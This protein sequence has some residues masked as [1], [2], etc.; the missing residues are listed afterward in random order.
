[1]RNR[2]VPRIEAR[3]D[4]TLGT[5]LPDARPLAGGPIDVAGPG[6]YQPSFRPT[7]DGSA[8]EYIIITGESL[9]AEFQRL[10]DWKLEKGVQSAVRTVEWI[11]Q[12]YPN[13]ADRAE[14]VRF[15]IRD[16][17]QNW[18]TLFVLLGGDTDIIPPRY[19]HITSPKAETIPADMYYSCLE[20]NW[21]GDMD[22]RFG[23]G[24]TVPTDGDD[25]PDN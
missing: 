6:P 25:T 15:F 18:G 2:I 3:F 7:A 19:A 22:D 24:K 21:N 16:A 12:T 23:E 10:A 17:Y 11:D 8:V 9:E 14:R 4:Q 5:L 20:G 13:G 1:M